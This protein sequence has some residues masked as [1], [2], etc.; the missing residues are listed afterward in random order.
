MNIGISKFPALNASEMCPKWLR[1]ASRVWTSSAESASAQIL[2][3]S[4]VSW[5]WWTVFWWEKPI[6]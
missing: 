6:A 2:P 1:I 5:K 4:L 3:P